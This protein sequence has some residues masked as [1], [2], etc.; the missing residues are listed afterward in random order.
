MM[1]DILII[2]LNLGI[3]VSKNGKLIFEATLIIL[4]RRVYIYPSAVVHVRVL[5]INVVLVDSLGDCGKEERYY[6]WCNRCSDSPRCNGV[7]ANIVLC[8]FTCKIL[9]YLVDCS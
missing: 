3:Y 1:F 4:T 2:L 7:R 5:Y 6:K 9:R 8:P